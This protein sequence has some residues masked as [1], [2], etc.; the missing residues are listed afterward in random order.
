MSSPLH[1][2][3]VFLIIVCSLIERNKSFI[4]K[5]CFDANIDKIERADEARSKTG[6]G[7][8]DGEKL[9]D[10]SNDK[11]KKHP[12]IASS[13]ASLSLSNESTKLVDRHNGRQMFSLSFALLACQL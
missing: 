8:V 12:S 7:R 3:V 13:S 1:T 4:I 2:L 9:V 6:R 5:F 10:G 11:K